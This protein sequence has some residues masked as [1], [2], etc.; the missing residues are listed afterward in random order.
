[1]KNDFA[2]LACRFGLC[3]HKVLDDDAKQAWIVI[4]SDSSRILKVTHD[5]LWVVWELIESKGRFVAYYEHFTCAE[6]LGRV[7]E[8]CGIY[9]Y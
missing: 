5:D 6:A 4:K 7:L 9:D 8:C 3:C 1:M 2:K